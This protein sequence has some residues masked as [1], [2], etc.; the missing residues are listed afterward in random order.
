[1]QEI[2]FQKYIAEFAQHITNL[3]FLVYI[4]QEGTGS[5]G[6]ITDEKKER[7]LSFSIDRSGES[8]S[9]NYGPPNQSCGTGWIIDTLPSDIKTAEDVE[10]ALYA[11]P[12]RYCQG[13]K[14]FTT[15][16]QHLKT[17]QSSSK[18][19]LFV[20]SFKCEK[21]EAPISHGN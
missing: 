15:V 17:Y 2:H 5:Y 20:A 6:F 16:E 3:G 10:K 14:H 4:A 9:G 11:H 12:P 8:L 21:A 13:W 19:V 18:Y 7:V 1:M